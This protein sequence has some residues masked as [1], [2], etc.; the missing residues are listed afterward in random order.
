MTTSKVITVSRRDKSVVNPSQPRG[1]V[2]DRLGPSN[3]I[4]DRLGPH[5]HSVGPWK[6][7]TTPIRRQLFSA[8]QKTIVPYTHAEDQNSERDDRDKREVILAK[9]MKENKDAME[10][11]RLQQKELDAQ[12]AALLGAE[13][14]SSS[15]N[16]RREASPGNRSR[17]HHSDSSRRE[18]SRCRSRSRE[19]GSDGSGHKKWIDSLEN[20]R[21]M[22]KSSLKKDESEALARKVAELEKKLEAAN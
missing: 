2:K 17:T 5:N 18:T 7:K 12:M 14:V 4:S 11:M 20:E 6:A 15:H 13:E 1:S 9:K 8:I 16:R 10:A 19:G 22:R 21:D 3:H